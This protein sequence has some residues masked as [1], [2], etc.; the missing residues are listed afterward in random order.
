MEEKAFLRVGI[1]L[2]EGAN[3][4][5]CIATAR[6]LDFDHLSTPASEETSA[7]GA[8]YMMAKTQNP[9]TG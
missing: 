8:C 5:S 7:M 9:V 4:A 2:E 6:P 3:T 1:I